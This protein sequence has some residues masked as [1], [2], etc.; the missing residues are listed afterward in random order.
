MKILKEVPVHE[1][2]KAHDLATHVLVNPWRGINAKQTTK[3]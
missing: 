3:G 1:V 2:G